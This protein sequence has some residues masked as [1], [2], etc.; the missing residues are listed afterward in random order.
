[1]N[2]LRPVT[3]G[4]LICVFGAGGERDRKKRPLMGPA[5][6]QGCDIAILT[7]DNPRREDP[8]AIF[9][10]ILQGIHNTGVVSVIPDRIAAIHRALKLARP[11]DCVLIAG[12]GHEV[13]Q[14]VGDQRLP[15]DDREVARTW[16][17]EQART[18]DGCFPMNR[19]Q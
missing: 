11:G 8:R 15:L 9:R 16:L 10:D 3:A 7:N 18:G 14:I 12:K 17:Y 5:V 13:C 19:D 2:A 4:R 6:E 1:M